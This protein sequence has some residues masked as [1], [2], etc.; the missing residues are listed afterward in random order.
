MAP[1]R[2]CSATG[3]VSGG[4][5]YVGGLVGSVYSGTLSACSATGSVSGDMIM[6]AG[7]LGVSSMA[8]SRAVLPPVRSAAT[9]MW[10]GWL[11]MSIMA[12]SRAVMPPV[13]STAIGYVGGLVGR[14]YSGTLSACY[15]TG[16]VNGE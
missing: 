1:S 14:V 7:W 16:S 6:W 4:R 5:Y 12:P 9:V 15:A 13:R 2:A 10:A 11:G 3:S 8:P